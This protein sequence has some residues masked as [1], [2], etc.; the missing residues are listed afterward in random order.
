MDKPDTVV[1]RFQWMRNAQGGQSYGNRMEIR[2]LTE[3]SFAKYIFPRLRPGIV[4]NLVEY[5]SKYPTQTHYST[6]WR[7]GDK[8]WKFAGV[9][10]LEELEKDAKES[11][12]AIEVDDFNSST[13]VQFGN[14]AD[15]DNV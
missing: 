3:V 7:D 5:L 2:L 14:I 4:K 11:G 10:S 8:D 15:S 9:G 6:I 13:A 12:W 1:T